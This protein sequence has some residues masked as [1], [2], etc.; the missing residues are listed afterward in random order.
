MA[1]RSFIGLEHTDGRIDSIYC[2]NEGEPS[3]KAGV[4]IHHYADT[5]KVISLLLLGDISVLGSEIGSAHAFD[6]LSHPTWCKAYARDRGEA[7]CAPMSSYNRSAYL[8]KANA[9]NAEYAYLFTNGVW[10]CCEP[11]EFPA[12]QPNWQLLSNF[13]DTSK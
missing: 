6:D 10:M 11:S 1:T 9:A 5:E 13:L 4:L 8:A 3:D 12:H 2:H 7:F